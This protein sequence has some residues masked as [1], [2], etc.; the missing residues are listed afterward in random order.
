MATIKLTTGLKVYDIEDERGNIRGQ[1]TINPSDLNFFARAKEMKEN[2][3]VW[4]AEI[5]NLGGTL[6]DEAIVE[7]IEEYDRK[8]KGEIIRVFDDDTTSNIV[9]GNQN[10]FN[11]Y[12]GVT[13]VE[14]FL[15]AIM[16]VIQKEIEAE[17]KNSVARV[18][19]YTK[20]VR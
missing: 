13:F 6:D 18:E 12:K 9:F 1:I 5:N 11:T 20:Q 14:R 15:T 8:V 19:K 17:K 2:I 4:V 16:P 10:V 3:E 7:K